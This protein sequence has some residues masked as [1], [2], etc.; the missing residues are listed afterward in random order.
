[1]KKIALLVAI[2]AAA[3]CS[4][5]KD[6]AT[7]A[8]KD[9]VV[10]YLHE[11]VPAEIRQQADTDKSGITT[12]DEWKVFLGGGTGLLALLGWIGKKVIDGKIKNTDDGLDAHAEKLSSAK[13]DIWSAINDLKEKKA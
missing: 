4:S 12:W 10:S 7:N 3:S 9:A 6:M 11:N 1:M 8:A 2:T 5:F 13:K